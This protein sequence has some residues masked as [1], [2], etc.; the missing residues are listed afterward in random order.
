MQ[1]RPAVLDNVGQ[2]HLAYKHLHA[3]FKYLIAQKTLNKLIFNY[4]FEIL[5]TTHNQMLTYCDP[6]LS[7][8]LCSQNSQI[9]AKSICLYKVTNWSQ[10]FPLVERSLVSHCH[11][12]K[13]EHS[14]FASPFRT[15]GIK[16]TSFRNDESGREK[17]E[18][19]ENRR[20]EKKSK[21]RGGSIIFGSHNKQLDLFSFKK[22]VEKA[23]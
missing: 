22:K 6:L 4:C 16:I 5:Q 13:Q 15:F 8:F 11:C 17:D 7:T 21:R 18:P 20:K 3:C 10:R 1:V 19:K 2:T 12:Q 23:V 9:R 14:S